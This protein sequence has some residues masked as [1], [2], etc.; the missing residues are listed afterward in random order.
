MILWIETKSTVVYRDRR[1]L[2][3]DCGMGPAATGGSGWKRVNAD[4]RCI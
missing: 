2:P 1:F 4:T 3:N